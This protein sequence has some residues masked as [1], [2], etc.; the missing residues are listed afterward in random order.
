MSEGMP[1]P[2]VT[3]RGTV[4]PDWVDYNGHLRDAYYGLIFSFATDAW[5]DQIGLDAKGRADTGHTLYT[6]ESHQNFLLEV[7]VDTAV[8]V[9]TQI[10]GADQKRVQ[11]FHT[12]LR[13]DNAAVLATTEL[14]LCNI[15][16]TGPRSA[17]FA[18]SVASRL[19]PVVQAH[20]HW[21]RP[22]QAGRSIALPA[23]R[24]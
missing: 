1:D 6:L 7:Q 9:H 15:D 2:L 16:T 24:P 12:L 4:S 3:W 14:M 17:A 20:R 22:P 5:M 11:V 8:E 10:L 23:P 18:P 19:A 21:P 13:S